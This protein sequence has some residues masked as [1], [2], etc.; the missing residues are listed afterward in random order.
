MARCKIHKRPLICPSCVGA[1]G[2][3][4]G[5]KSTST[6]KVRAAK[7]NAQMRRRDDG[8]RAGD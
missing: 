7:K 2:G 4:K 8:R 5:G 1:K 6:K 3:K